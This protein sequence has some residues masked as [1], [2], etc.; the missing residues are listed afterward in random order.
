MKYLIFF[1]AT[2]GNFTHL[3]SNLIYLKKKNINFTI[4]VLNSDVYELSKFF[5][6][7]NNVIYL[8]KKKNLFIRYIS[9]LKAIYFLNKKKFDVLINLSLNNHWK[10]TIFNRIIKTKKKYSFLIDQESK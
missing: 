8:T 2:L 6:I 5:K 1:D 10:N 3:Y 9:I 4:L 7:S